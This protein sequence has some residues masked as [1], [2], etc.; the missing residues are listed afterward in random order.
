MM[1]TTFTTRS[2]FATILQLLGEAQADKKNE[3]AKK[4][5]KGNEQAQRT[6]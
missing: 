4:V 5:P 3:E 6:R 2:R 1:P